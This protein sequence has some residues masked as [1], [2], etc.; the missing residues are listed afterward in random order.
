MSD[1]KIL[2]FGATGA[3]G[4]SVVE[5]LSG[6]YPIRAVVRN[7]TTEKA[8][9][10]A[11]KGVEL[12]TGDLSTG[13]PDSAFQ[14][15]HAV[16]LVTVVDHTSFDN[17][18]DQAI[19]IVDAAK[20][21]GVKQFI[22]STLPYV[23]VESNGKVKVPHFD[24]KARVEEYVRKQGF[25]YSAFP[26]LAFYYQNFETFFPPKPDDNGNLV[27]AIP[28][29]SSLIAVDVSQ[30]GIV[31]KGIIDNP[32][33][34]NGQFIPVAGDK[35]SLQYYA[36]ALSE[37]EGKKVILNQIP[38]EVFA[39][40]GFPMAAEIAAMFHWFNDYSFYGKKDWQDSKKT[41]PELRTFKAYLASK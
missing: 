4:G 5:Y 29:T 24:A 39:S 32:E 41:Y 23:S 6:H 14:G 30:V 16:F 40:F 13:V 33:K 17:E 37:K 18:H 22:F 3:Q 11:Q 10:L 20:K 15:I 26:A 2:V 8:V 7:P 38:H 27:L 9:A 21:A 25:Q 34:W 19:L 35:E 36:D 31:V 28:I 1:K 12:V